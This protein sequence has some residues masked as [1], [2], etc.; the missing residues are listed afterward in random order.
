MIFP[1]TRITTAKE[2]SRGAGRRA[3]LLITIG[4]LPALA[5]APAAQAEC[6]N[7]QLRQSPRVSNINPTTGQPYDASLPDCRAYEQVSP[8]EKE[9]GS[10]G[11][12]SFDSTEQENNHTMRSSSNGS[13][14]TYGGEAFYQVEA[15]A[16]GHSTFEEQYTSERTTNGWETGH[17]NTLIPEIAPAYSL[18]V[19]ATNPTNVEESSGGSEDFYIEGGALYEYR[20]SSGTLTDLTPG[21]GADVQG[22]LGIGG[23]GAEEGSYI[24]FVAGGVL[25]LGGSSTGCTVN[26]GNNLIEGT[27]CN[28]YL[29]HGSDT[30]FI[31]T[32]SAND[33]NEGK[34]S[35]GAGNVDWSGPGERTAEVSPNGRY[36][37]FGSD[38]PLTGQEAGREIFRYDTEAHQLTCV[39]CESLSEPQSSGAFNMVSTGAAING[40]GHQRYMLNDGRVLFDTGPTTLLEYEPEN[41]GTCTSSTNTNGSIFIPTETGCISLIANDAILAD[42]SANGSD[43]FFTTTQSLIPQDQDEITDLYDAHENG[44]FTPPPE[45]T[46]QTQNAC[47]GPITPP[48]TLN[49]TPTTTTPPNTETPPPPSGTTKPPTPPPPTRAQKLAKALKTCHAKHNKKQRTTCETTARKLYG[50]IPPNKKTKKHHKSR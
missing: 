10:G 50:P 22:L 27:G 14:I 37:A 28:L 45:P 11:V 32:L 3:A 46:C 41:V 13:S 25:A 35:L 38:L 2:R 24:Y 31:A 12:F 48:P 16:G 1:V 42:A 17:G 30:T 6:S 29:R 40:A 20:P 21:T 8:T 33:E 4:A 39:S 26:S 7:E 36:V 9:G 15:S 34:E 19:S 43:I 44:G 47:P 23:E 5:L 49:N 18:P